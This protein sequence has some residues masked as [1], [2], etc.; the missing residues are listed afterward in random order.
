METRKWRLS[1]DKL[2]IMLLD[3][4][5]SVWASVAVAEGL[6]SDPRQVHREMYWNVGAATVDAGTLYCRRADGWLVWQCDA[7]LV[8]WTS[9]PLTLTETTAPGA[10]TRAKRGQAEDVS[11]PAD[12]A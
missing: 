2:E 7:S 8:S 9:V 6:P 10:V 11:D 4:D 1:P 3:D 5:G 12:P